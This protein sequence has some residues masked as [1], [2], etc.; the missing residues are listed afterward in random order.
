MDV[1]QGIGLLPGTESLTPEIGSRFVS[2]D[3]Y[4]GAIG[5]F[6]NEFATDQD[7]DAPGEAV[8]DAGDVDELASCE[9]DVKLMLGSLEAS[10]VEY[11]FVTV[12]DEELSFKCFQ[13]LSKGGRNVV[14]NTCQDSVVPYRMRWMVQHLEIWRPDQYSSL[15]S[16]FDAFIVAEP[17]ELN[18]IEEV[19]SKP[20]A[21][22]HINTWTPCASDLSGR[23]HFEAPCVV[24][25]SVCLGDPGIPILSLLDAL[26]SASFVGVPRMFIHSRTS[27]LF[28]DERK[29][30]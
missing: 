19:G 16:S 17:C 21:R 12:P 4:L 9:Q 13:V 22:G 15:P 18:I 7:P 25:P 14:I 11:Q 3:G 23:T 6:M 30:E 27:G 2:F 20:E 26:E 5:A 28:F 1:S 24:K 10:I 29:V 8:A